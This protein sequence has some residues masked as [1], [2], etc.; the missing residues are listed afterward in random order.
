MGW[1]IIVVSTQELQEGLEVIA[2]LDVVQNICELREGDH[3]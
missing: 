2:T 3:I 1:P